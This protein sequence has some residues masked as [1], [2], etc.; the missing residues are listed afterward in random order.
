[1]KSKTYRMGNT[2][3][4]YNCHL[5]LQLM[6]KDREYEIVKKI[7]NLKKDKVNE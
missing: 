4:V 1:M 6:V 7:K 5:M 2:K 3:R